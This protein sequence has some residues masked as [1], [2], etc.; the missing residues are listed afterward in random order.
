M[1]HF[2]RR[3]KIS[4]A[5]ILIVIAGYA[6][7]RF[8]FSSSAVPKEFEQARLH[9]ALISQT[10]VDISNQISSGLEQ[11]NEFDK[12]GKYKEAFELTGDLIKKSQEVRGRA[13]ELSREL[14][15]MTKALAGIKSTE[16]RGAALEAIANH[17][18]VIN[19][20]I[21][22]SDYL[23][24]LLVALRSR[25]EGGE[26]DTEISTLIQQINAE[27]TAINNFNRQAGQAMERFDAIVMGK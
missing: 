5:F 24:Q 18:T 20:L 4:L 9:G 8:S 26:P 22:Y 6:V 16:A 27:V 12:A 13:V 2:S 11:V 19:R 7:G 23:A 25:F 1:F 21:S 10:I 15:Q 3:V 14:E 17:L